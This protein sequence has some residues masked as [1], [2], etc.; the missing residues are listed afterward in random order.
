MTRFVVAIPLVMT[1]VLLVTISTG[2][3][4]PMSTAHANS[5]DRDALVALYNATDGANWTNN[6][7]WLSGEPLGSWHGVRVDS[8]G[9][10]NRLYLS[11]NQLTGTIP[12]ELGNLANL[13]GLYLSSNQLT[14]TIPRELGNLANLDGLYLSS[15]QLTGTI[16]RELGNLANL[17][18]LNLTSPGLTS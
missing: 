13:D 15:N 17:E 11:S 12:R 1:L 9:R 2:V 8:D 4:V 18:T 10:V 5:G 14:G 3:S 16:P 6:D 7:N